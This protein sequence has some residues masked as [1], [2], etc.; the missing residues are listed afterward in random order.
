[1]LRNYCAFSR[2]RVHIDSFLS[3]CFVHVKTRPPPSPDKHSDRAAQIN[4]SEISRDP[5]MCACAQYRQRMVSC[6]DGIRAAGLIIVLYELRHTCGCTTVGTTR[7][8]VCAICRSRFIDM[9]HVPQSNLHCSLLY[10]FNT[11]T[12][13]QD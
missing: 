6:S 11:L 7:V 8:V 10:Y 2:A 1:M 9:S 4:E 5:S 13:H 3:F 12:I